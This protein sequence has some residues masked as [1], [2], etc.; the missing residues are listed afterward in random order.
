MRQ[1]LLD[2]AGRLFCSSICYI[3]WISCVE[4][5]RACRQKSISYQCDINWCIVSM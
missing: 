3:M 1:G 5:F 4:I 2:P